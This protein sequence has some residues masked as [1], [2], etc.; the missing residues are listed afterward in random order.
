MLSFV[1]E[2]KISLFNIV[3]SFSTMTTSNNNVAIYSVSHVIS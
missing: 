2:S 3:L 1:F